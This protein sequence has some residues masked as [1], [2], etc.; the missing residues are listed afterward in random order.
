MLCIYLL[1]ITTQDPSQ[2]II[3]YENET[4]L[5]ASIAR[6]LAAVLVLL[7]LVM[8]EVKKIFFIIIVF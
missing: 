1:M 6:S 8:V 7:V 2:N 5:A 4:K 3:V